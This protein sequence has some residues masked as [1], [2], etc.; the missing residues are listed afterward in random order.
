MSARDKVTVRVLVLEVD[1]REIEAKIMGSC[2][3]KNARC[4]RVLKATLYLFMAAP[5]QLA[6]L[7]EG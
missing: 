1:M 2:N 7:V 5:M 4:D 3:E 6:H